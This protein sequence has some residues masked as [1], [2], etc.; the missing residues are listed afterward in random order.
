MLESGACPF[1]GTVPNYTIVDGNMHISSGDWCLAMPLRVFE[2]GM[3]K[4]SAV[5][6]KHRLKQAEVIPIRGRR[7]KH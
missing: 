7:D 3:A 4:A 6:A 2:A 1:I 5:I